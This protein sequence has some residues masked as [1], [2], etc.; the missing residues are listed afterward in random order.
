MTMDYSDCFSF[1]LLGVYDLVHIAMLLHE[2]VLHY[3][4]PACTISYSVFVQGHQLALYRISAVFRND[5]KGG[6]IKI[7][8]NG[9]RGANLAG[10]KWH[11]A[12][13]LD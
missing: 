2:H 12:C 5:F 10:C 3:A 6:K 13:K 1:S 4:A 8:R 11:K 9:V 7:S